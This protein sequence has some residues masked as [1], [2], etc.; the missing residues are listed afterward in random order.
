MTIH[1]YTNTLINSKRYDILTEK[2]DPELQRKLWKLSDVL[3]KDKKLREN[4]KNNVYNY[5]S[6]YPILN[7]KPYD[8]QYYEKSSFCEQYNQEEGYHYIGYDLV[9]ITVTVSLVDETKNIAKQLNDT[10][11][12]INSIFNQIN[13]KLDIEN[14]N[15]SVYCEQPDLY[16][17]LEYEINLLKKYIDNHPECYKSDNEKVIK[18]YFVIQAIPT[19]EL[20]DSIEYKVNEVKERTVKVKIKNKDQILNIYDQFIKYIKI[21][22]PITSN[23]FNFIHIADICRILDISSDKI[24]KLICSNIKNINLFKEFDYDSADEYEK[25]LKKQLGKSYLMATQG[26]SDYIVYSFK[27]KSIYWINIEHGECNKFYLDFPYSSKELEDHLHNNDKKKAV[28]E[29]LK[30]YDKQKGYNLLQ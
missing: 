11:N 30:E 2:Y 4:I 27:N 7:K 25:Y 23:S 26:D 21:P 14:I 9:Y 15:L 17:R 16:K 22:R 18:N 6:K 10:Y 28:Q 13:N 24:N 8:I 5:M 20:L 29:L 1:D 12:Q 19:Q 3:N